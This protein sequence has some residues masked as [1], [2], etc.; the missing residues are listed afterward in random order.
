[1]LLVDFKADYQASQI[2]GGNSYWTVLSSILRACLP[3]EVCPAA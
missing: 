1:M 3:F 2:K